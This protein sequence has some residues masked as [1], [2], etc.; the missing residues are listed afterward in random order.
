MAQKSKIL[1]SSFYKS[2]F[3][4]NLFLFIGHSGFVKGDGTNFEI[5]ESFGVETSELYLEVKYTTVDEYLDQFV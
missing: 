5:E 1:I 2:P 4:F 3:P